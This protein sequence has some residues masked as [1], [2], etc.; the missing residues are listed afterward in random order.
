LTTARRIAGTASEWLREGR[1]V[2]AALLVGID[3]SAPLEPGALM[4]IAEDGAIEGSITG[5]CVE[6]AVVGEAQG[7]FAGGDARTVTYGITDELAGSVG[8]TCGGTVHVFV[9]ELS[10]EE[11]QIEAAARDAVAAGRPVAIATL[12]DGPG[13]GR[14]LAVVDGEVDGALGGP[15]KLDHSVARDAEGMLAQG[16]SAIRRYGSDGATLGAEVAVHVHVFAPPPKMLIFG[17]IDFSAALARVASELGFEVTICDPREPF[18]E[19][20]RFRRAAT[21]LLAWPEEALE[22]VELGPRDAVLVFTHDPKFD[23]PALAGA[24]E[25]EA[26]Y[27]GALGSRKTTADRERRLRESGVAESELARIHAPCGLDIGAATPEEVAVSVLAEIIAARSGRAGTPLREG[28]EPIH[29]RAADLP[30]GK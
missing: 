6:A 28:S 1:R 14:K 8:L 20:P 29:S 24:L 21:T 7:I 5:G 13:A 18:L 9:H 23:Q 15:G 26:L 12:L 30:L 4:L 2:V 3:G 16:H 11:A 19:A 27:I 10:G 22:Q 17:A 25:T